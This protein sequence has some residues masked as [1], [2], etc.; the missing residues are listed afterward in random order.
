[1]GQKGIYTL[2]VPTGGGRAVASLAFVQRHTLENNMRRIIYVIPYTSIIEQNALAF[3]CILG[4][5]NVLERHSAAIFD[6][7]EE[8]NG[9]KIRQRLATENW[10]HRAVVGVHQRQLVFAVQRLGDGAGLRQQ[11]PSAVG[12]KVRTVR[13]IDTDQRAIPPIPRNCHP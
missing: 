11:R 7:D 10:D 3:R 12:R 4:E 1:M 13:R 5:N 9:E 2:T 8:T 6:S